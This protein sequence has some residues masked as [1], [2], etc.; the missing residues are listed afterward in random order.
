MLQSIT[1]VSKQ[2]SLGIISEK[3]YHMV[4]IINKKQSQKR[5]SQHSDCYTKKKN[6]DWLFKKRNAIFDLAIFALHQIIWLKKNVSYNFRLKY[7]LY[8]TDR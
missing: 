3:V 4:F 1:D 6:I 7:L 5:G 2:D 8:E